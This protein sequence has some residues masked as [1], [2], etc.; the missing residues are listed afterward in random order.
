MKHLKTY[1]SIKNL[2]FKLKDNSMY[3]FYDYEMGLNKVEKFLK[4][5]LINNTINKSMKEFLKNVESKK[6]FN[7]NKGAILYY[8]D[9][10]EN[11]QFDVFDYYNSRKNK[12]D[13]RN[14]KYY[15]RNYYSYNIEY[16][17][18]KNDKIISLSKEEFIDKINFIND[19]NKYNI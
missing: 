7:K 4:L 12:G 9:G 6:R 2:N 10:Y 17:D 13:N 14:L 15:L 8:I 16:I 19:A 1:E 11:S 3:I 18:I 5:Y